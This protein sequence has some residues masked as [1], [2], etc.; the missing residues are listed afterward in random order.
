MA[1]KP[2]LTRRDFLKAGAGPGRREPAG[3]L[4]TG[5]AGREAHRGP[6]QACRGRQAGRRRAAAATGCTRPGR[7]CHGGARRCREARRGRQASRRREAGARSSARSL[8]ASWKG[9]RSSPMPRSSRRRFKEAPALAELVKAGKLPPV[10]RAHRPGAAGDQAAPRDRQVRRHLAPWLHRPGDQWN[11]F[12]SASGPDHLLFWD[13]TGEKIVPNIAKGCELEDGGKIT[14]LQL[15]KGMKWSD[16]TPFTADDFVF[17][18][19]D[20]YS[21]QGSVPDA[22]RR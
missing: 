6:G 1:T 12:R 8:S 4:R 9:R 11:G 13:Y 16:G 15:R 5:R 2:G 21:E 22:D 3:R 18:F 14:V 17:W 19:E 20:L 7:R 10:E